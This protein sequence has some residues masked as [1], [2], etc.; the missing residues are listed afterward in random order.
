M[1]SRKDLMY[2]VLSFT[3]NEL[4]QLF[5]NYKIVPG[6]QLSKFRRIKALKKSL[7]LLSKSNDSDMKETI[8]DFLGCRITKKQFMDSVSNWNY[9]EKTLFFHLEKDGYKTA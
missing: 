7:L 2:C 8:N 4:D 6:N 1:S 3:S 5:S 9:F